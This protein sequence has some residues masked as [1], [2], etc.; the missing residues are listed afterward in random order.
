[1]AIRMTSESKYHQNKVL[2]VSLWGK[3]YFR[4]FQKKILQ[5]EYKRQ[6]ADKLPLCMLNCYSNFQGFVEK[7]NKFILELTG[8][9]M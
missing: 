4:P 8:K 7:G 3:T 6:I 2:D 9:K 1:M 5:P